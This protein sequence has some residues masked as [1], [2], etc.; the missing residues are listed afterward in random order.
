MFLMQ[1]SG[2]I[3]LEEKISSGVEIR[4]HAM[5]LLGFR[6][7]FGI[8]VCKNTKAGLNFHWPNTITLRLTAM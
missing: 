8:C 2:S 1:E 7:V 5:P 3:E 4:P 6:L